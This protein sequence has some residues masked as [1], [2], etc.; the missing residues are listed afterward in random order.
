[1]SIAA[2]SAYPSMVPIA[3]LVLRSATR[4]LIGQRSIVRIAIKHVTTDSVDVLQSAVPGILQRVLTVVSLHSGGFKVR[5]DAGDL[6]LVRIPLVIVFLHPCVVLLRLSFVGCD[7][8]IEVLPL[9]V[10]HRLVCVDP[11][12]LL[13]QRP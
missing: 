10:D 9:L 13:N 8:G 4:P 1:M 7:S 3:V 5:E 6:G 12:P 11:A 2:T